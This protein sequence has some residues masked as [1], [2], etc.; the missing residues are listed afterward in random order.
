[1]AGADSKHFSLS[2]PSGRK[3]FH[4]SLNSPP[5]KTL[6][7]S[8]STR[9]GIFLITTMGPHLKFYLI[10]L[11]IL[12]MPSAHAGT[13]DGMLQG[14]SGITISNAT[15]NFSLQQAGLII[16]S[17]SVVPLTTSCY[18]STDGTVIGIPNPAGNVITSINYGSGS[19]PAGVY[20]VETTFYSGSQETLPSPE[21]RLQLTGNGT[22]TIS[23]QV[24]FP[25]NATGMRVYIGTASGSEMLQGQ[26]S[27]STAQFNQ[28]A[29]LTSGVMTP[30]S[31][32]SVCSIAFND[33][34]IP[35]SGY[36]VSLISPTGNAYPG[37]PQAWQLNG[38]LNGTVNISNGAPLWNGVIVYP[39][40]I[41]AQ[42]L[43]HGPQSISGSL[44][45]SGY[46]LFNVGAIG[47]G[48]STPGWP[49]D[50][51][52]GAINA[53][54]GYLYNGV[55]PVAHILVGNGTAYVDSATIPN[56]ALPSIHYQTL[57]AAGTGQPQEPGINF[58]SAFTLGDNPGNW[59]GVNLANTGVTAGS[60]TNP[61]LTVNAQ[62]Q[63]TAASNGSSFPTVKSLIITTG[64]CTTAG[65]AYGSCTFSPAWGSAFADTAYAVTCTP[66]VPTSGGTTSTLTLYVSTKTTTGFALTLQNGDTTS[67]DATT[68]AEIDC[69]GVH[70]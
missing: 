28:G 20:Y 7:R 39:Q 47:F 42:P 11:S 22:L 6:L 52:N 40:P 63:V 43:N 27:S 16:G 1:M 26:T 21:L 48:T 41:V 58:G 4:P 49:V 57:Y 64:I 61:S 68:G 10:L 29:A 38:G 9:S 14:P 36:N 13:I 56:S 37:W 19:L 66:T 33:T 5:C 18:T 12:A 8:N 50:V 62:G 31:N 69:V 45:L 46:N 55:A 3:Q 25:Q 70:P 24:S 2:E 35:Y 32:T 17:G 65:S 54:G 51:E 60:Y 23:P 30:S 67:A 44:G 53:S 34:I 15:L 59:T